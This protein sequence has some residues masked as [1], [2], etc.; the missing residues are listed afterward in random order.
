MAE[1]SLTEP[2]PSDALKRVPPLGRHA[3]EGP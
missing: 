1:R 3:E 2:G